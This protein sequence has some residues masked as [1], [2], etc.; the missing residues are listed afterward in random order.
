MSRDIPRRNAL[1]TLVLATMATI[2]LAFAGELAATLKTSTSPSPRTVRA[3]AVAHAASPQDCPSWQTQYDLMVDRNTNDKVITARHRG[4][5][6]GNLPEDSLGA[7]AAAFNRCQ[8]AV[9]T[10]VRLTKDGELVVFHD[11]RVGKM[12]EPTYDPDTN[13]GPNRRVKDL[14]LAELQQ[15]SL[16]KPDRTPSHYHVPTVEEL[17]NYMLD[18]DADSILHLEFK[19]PSAILPAAQLLSEYDYRYPQQKLAHRVVLKFSAA[20]FPTPQKWNNALAAKGI[21]KNLLVML[22]M[23]PGIAKEI[24]HQ[25]EFPNPAGFDLKSNA[26]RSVAWWGLAP[27]TQAPIIEVNIKDSSEFLETEP[28]FGSPFGPF[29]APASLDRANTKPNTVAEWVA[30]VHE[31]HKKLAAFVPVPDAVMFSPGPAAGYTVPNTWGYK[32]PIPITDA[33]YNNTSSCCYQLADRRQTSVY[34]AEQHDWR[35]NLDFLEK[36]G[37]T[38]LTSDD[39]DTVEL[40]AEE[41][42]S[43]NHSARPRVTQPPAQMHSV[44]YSLYKDGH[45]PDSATVNIKGWDGGWSSA[46]KGEVCLFT[47][48]GQT[49]WTVSCGYDDPYYSPVLKISTIG[50]GRMHITDPKTGQCLS[51]N[52][53]DWYLIYWSTDCNSARAEWQRTADHR[54]VDVDGRQ[55]NFEWQDRY[56]Y[57]YPF[58]YN[59]LT[60][61]DTSAW[62]VW[63]LVPVS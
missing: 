9:E 34:A 54:F 58:T 12:L 48:P 17:F 42:G 33:F 22:K 49:L 8:P 52:P 5:F 11:A 2:V 1:L 31:T 62:S 55:I 4:A 7:F 23:D 57:G 35:M 30:L 43:L 61:G 32:T 15:K 38:V 21:D 56:T 24:D 27:M 63:K 14:T 10:D 41:L 19:E 16:L 6:D 3:G 26:S 39:S 28:I 13:K 18:H 53:G 47:Y 50:H 25:A 45:V 29:L 51:T 37:A 59:M 46:W 60:D 36:I 44:L 40:Y 20:A